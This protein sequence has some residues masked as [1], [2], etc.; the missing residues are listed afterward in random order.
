MKFLRCEN[1]PKNTLGDNSAAFSARVLLYPRVF[2]FDLAQKGFIMCGIAGFLQLSHESLPEQSLTWLKS[3]TDAMDYRGPDGDGYFIENQVAL[4]HRRLSIIDLGAGAQP[5]HNYSQT[6]EIGDLCV[7]FNGEIY[8][9]QEL[10]RTLQEKGFTF[11]T[12]SDTEVILYSWLA[13]GA[14]CVKH[15]EGMF[16]FALWDKKQKIL[17][18]AR[19]RFGKKPFYYTLQQG[20]CIFASELT[21]LSKFPHLSLSVHPRTLMRFLAYEYVPTP[22]SIYEEVHKLPPAHSLLI[23]EG[24]V[25]LQR[26]WDIPCPENTATHQRSEEDLGEELYSL[27]SQAVK[28]RMVS[29]VPL[30]VF[31]SGGIDSSIVTGLMAEHSSNIKSFSIGFKESSYDESKYA[32]LVSNYYGTNHYEHILSADDCANILPHVA[33]RLDEPMA[34]ASIAPTYLLSQATRKEVTV[35]LG[36]DGAD[37]LFAGYEHFIGFQVAEQYATWPHWL[38]K[39]LIE[40]ITPHLPASAG[41]INLRLATATFLQGAYAPPWQRVQSLLTS[42]S[43]DMQKDLWNPELYAS[44]SDFLTNDQLFA[45]TKELFNH[46]P[47]SSGASNLDRAFYVYAR[48]FMLDDILTKI[49]RCSMLNSLEVRSPFL[50]TLGAEFISKLPVGY[51]LNKFRRKYLLKKAFSKLLP[52]EILTRNKRGFQ[53]PVAEWLRTSL[54]P[55]VEELLGEQ[56]LLRQGIFRTT[57]VR[58]LVDA[59]MSGKEDLRKPLWT[60]L[61]L[62]LWWKAHAPKITLS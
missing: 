44:H 28:R 45:P 49:D 4:G 11:R 37:E 36:G 3:M 27:L 39:G 34:D 31:L 60:L 38:R 56:Y 32:R 50:D 10:R 18:C 8:N 40:K 29:D 57:A 53:I 55:L 25:L 52:R 59:H 19:D 12:N 30:G 21:S 54:R 7:T 1:V 46:W 43:V 5:M 61:V 48:Q 2:H 14:D 23:Q 13:Y 42:F 58:K 62:Q 9:F 17:F 22:Q 16:A 24:K 35:A 47:A 20:R 51:K 6:N 26:Y 15:F 41:Y 33:S